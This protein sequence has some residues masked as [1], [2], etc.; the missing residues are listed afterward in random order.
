M[1]L[2]R[3]YCAA[4]L[5]SFCLGLETTRAAYLNSATQLKN[6]RPGPFLSPVP[7]S[8]T[9]PASYQFSFEIQWHWGL[10]AEGFFCCHSTF[11]SSLLSLSP[12][13]FFLSVYFWRSLISAQRQV[14][15]LSWALNESLQNCSCLHDLRFSF[16]ESGPRYWQRDVT[17]VR[18]R[19]KAVWSACSRAYTR[20]CAS[21]RILLEH[22]IMSKTDGKRDKNPWHGHILTNFSG[23]KLLWQTQ[24][25]SR[26]IKFPLVVILVLPITIFN[27]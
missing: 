10:T 9:L 12:L 11:F 8:P 6:L 23:F 2:R 4:A 17:S 20:L 1:L 3:S 18:A 25:F 15:W 26:G 22:L 7:F 19:S 21:A 13:F 27:L 16:L 14:G 24:S 5:A